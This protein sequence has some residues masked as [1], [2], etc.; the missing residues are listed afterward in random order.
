MFHETISPTRGFNW[1]NY[2]VDRGGLSQDRMERTSVGLRNLGN[3][4]FMN[5][6]LQL[7][8]DF[9]KSAKLKG[10]YAGLIERM[11][12]TGDPVPVYNYVRE[13]DAFKT[14]DFGSM[15]DCAFFVD[16]SIFELTKDGAVPGLTLLHYSYL[17]ETLLY[18]ILGGLESCS[19]GIRARKPQKQHMVV[20]NSLQGQL[21]AT[22][23]QQL[24]AL[25]SCIPRCGKSLCGERYA[26]FSLTSLH[27]QW[28]HTI[29]RASVHSY[30]SSGSQQATEG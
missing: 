27:Q 29:S 6:G 19:C 26:S 24:N 23:L 12:S 10:R 22:L 25:C 16:R 15:E 5:A 9:V 21:G 7:L 13:C 4:C 11:A 1:V 20:L 28:G 18:P 8:I 3:T 17:A 14:I 2:F 30:L